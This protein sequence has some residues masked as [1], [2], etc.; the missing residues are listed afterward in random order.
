MFKKKWIILYVV[1]AV[2]VLGGWGAYKRQHNKGVPVVAD[3]VKQQDIVS[4]VTANGKI[5]AEN[6][7]ELSALVM[8]QIVNL[9][10]RE[11][12]PVKTGQFL[13]QIDRNRAVAEEAGSSAALKAS[14]SDRDSARATME[15]AQRDYDRTRLNY[16]AHITSESDY[17]KAQAS[18]E[19]ARANLQAAENRVDETRASL[20]A[21][22]DTLSKT[23]VR[24]P[25]D[26][27]VTTLRVKAGEVTVIGTM[28]NPG[29]QLMTISDM[30]SIQA[31]LMVDETD[32]PSIKV[33][34]D[35]VLDID[36][37]PGR[38]FKGV[39]TEVGHSPILP[40]DSDLQGLTTTSDAINFKVKVK[41]AD[42]PPEI[43]PGFS[44]TADIITGR[45]QNVSAVPLAAVV[46]RDS[47]TG[48]R[49][50]T[51][52]LKTE[53]GVYALRGEKAV[54]VPIATGISGGLMVELVEGPKPGEEI[55]AGPFK[56]LR[57]IK[58]GDHVT[59]MPE[60]QSKAAG[61]ASGG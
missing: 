26:G 10:V 18:L 54:F 5:Q 46:V 6:K 53:E 30:S 19:T 31:V 21:S 14:L 47:P 50:E 11:G 2:L 60:E 16:E 41:L 4:K 23:T 7:V 56:A 45:K 8:G 49:T 20:D 28:N 52:A 42:P 44:V 59:R 27:V 51:G 39:V 29:T 9:A 1:A 61:E 32:T 40:D 57:E 36:A 33:G 35:A 34:Q 24:S 17:Q 43:R 48:E 58:D 38:T 37:Y 13:L 12:D 25:I 55:V 3:K 15:Q 22:R